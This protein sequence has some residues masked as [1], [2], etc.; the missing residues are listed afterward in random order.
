MCACVCLQDADAASEWY[1]K[2]GPHN[3]I[4]RQYHDPSGPK[5]LQTFQAMLASLQPA[6]PIVYQNRC[7]ECGKMVHGYPT[8]DMCTNCN[9]P[10]PVMPLF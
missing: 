7:R 6:R 10:L 4:V 5:K 8:V 2:N 1:V 9:I 3:N